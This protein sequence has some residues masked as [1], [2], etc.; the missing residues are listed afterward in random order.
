[1]NPAKAAANSAAFSFP[2]ITCRNISAPEDDGAG[3]KIYSGHAKAS[4]VLAFEDNENVREYLVDAM[5]K[6][7]RMPTLVHQAI[8]KTLKDNPDQF[9]VLN[10]GM[11]IVAHGAEI[12]DKN[13]IMLLKRPSI[14]NG[15]QTQGE[16]QRYFDRRNKDEEFEPSIKF[17]VIV[18]DDDDLIAE[19]SIA[20]NFQNDVRAISIAGR[21][22]QLDELEEALQR[23]YPGTHLRKSESD[24]IA[25]GEYVDTEK[26]IQVIFALMPTSLIMEMD[27]DHDASKVFAYSQ[28]TRCL[29]LF[30]RL[31]EKKEDDEGAKKAYRFFLDVAGDAW[32]LYEKW[33]VHPLFKGTRIRS[34]ER[35]GG[36]IV[37]VPDGIIFPILGA[38]SA[39]FSETGRKWRFKIPSAFDEQELVDAAASA[40]MEIADHNPQ[41]MGKSK[42]CYS[43]LLRLTGIYARLLS[44]G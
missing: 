27:A 23:G 20:R 43:T 9:S 19:I 36:D 25:D 11:V 33:K 2:Y 38:L 6:Q 34:I 37:E 15:S 4:A 30:T 22:G 24:V 13:K 42:A 18:T 17:E 29:K 8:R 31:T 35:E 21:R 26:L 5:G 32:K 10:G 44:D 12:D 40:Y 41:T 28:K 14:I 39:F 16:L 3:R 1:M 7:K